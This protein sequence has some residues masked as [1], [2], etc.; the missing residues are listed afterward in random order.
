MS[1]QKNIQLIRQFFEEQINR[2]DLSR[3]EEF[4]SK[5]VII[6]GPASGQ[7][8]HGL[9]EAKKIDAS[10]I[11]AYPRK[12]F[13][14]E[15]IF[16]SESRVMIRWICR[17]KHR[18]KYKGIAPKNPHFSIA[19][20]TIYR[21]DKGKIVEIWQHWD[22]LGLL[23]QIGEVSLRTSPIE[24]GYYLALLKNLGMDQYLEQA[25]LL[26]QRERQCLRSL[27]EGK[28]AK[29]TATDYKLSHRTIESHYERIKQKLMY[30][31]KR[32][33]LAAAQ[34]LEKLDLL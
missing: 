7:E 19:G 13:S 20:F 14:I 27:L 3:Y 29:E 28:T 12:T 26:S 9:P 2:D 1:A 23:E 22:R 34:L 33:L 24:P 18:G 4:V 32:D 10:Y 8:I 17:G 16:E 25:P 5:H 30:T 21:I 11:K 31:T 6:H 15:E